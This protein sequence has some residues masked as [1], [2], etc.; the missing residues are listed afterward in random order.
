MGDT[1]TEVTGAAIRRI[2][3]ADYVLV[4]IRKM[5][6]GGAPPTIQM[7]GESLQIPAESILNSLLA[8]GA[9]AHVVRT[10]YSS[11][12]PKPTFP[13][14][15]AAR[16]ELKSLSHQFTATNSGRLIVATDK[17]YLAW[18]VDADKPIVLPMSKGFRSVMAAATEKREREARMRAVTPNF[19][20]LDKQ[21][22]AIRR[23]TMELHVTIAMY[24]NL[25]QTNR[26]E[27]G[28][29]E[30]LNGMFEFL[31]KRPKAQPSSSDRADL[32]VLQSRLDQL[33]VQARTDLLIDP[34]DSQMSGKFKQRDAQSREVLR[35]V[36][37]AS[38]VSNVKVLVNNADVAP[39]A[40]FED[41]CE[42]VTFAYRTLLLT[43]R[44]DDAEK[45]IRDALDMLSSKVFDTTGLTSTSNPS[46]N[47]A[48]TQAG[49]P[50]SGDSALILII[51][52]KVQ[53][54]PTLVGN[55]PGPSTVGAAVV[56]MA[57]LLL[58]PSVM[59]NPGAAGALSAKLYRGLAIA[60]GIDGPAGMAERVRLIEATQSGDLSAIRKMSWSS[61]FM[62]SQGWC[63]GIGAANAI[64]F[65]FAITTDDTSTLR[66]WSKVAATGSG[67][68][69]GLA[70][71]SFGRFGSLLSRGIITGTASNALGVV[72]GVAAVV[73]GTITA[74]EEFGAGDTTGGWVATAGAVGGALSVA[75]FLVAAGAA[76]SATG[77]G[78]PVGM[79]L[80]VVG[81]VLAVGSGVVSAVR[82]YFTAG[83]QSLWIGVLDYLNRPG[84]PIPL[85][86]AERPKLR[87][88]FDDVYNNRK[89]ASFWDV[90]L[91]NA[92]D[93]QDLG[94]SVQ[95]IAVIVNESDGTVQTQLKTEARP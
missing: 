43:P 60:A 89:S 31:L 40:L 28:I 33:R 57:G 46:F 24:D 11:H 79:G 36:R 62:T 61:R 14:L 47:T 39:A 41:V 51:K 15:R 1:P 93:L 38:F 50:P 19:S 66:K 13:G 78:V 73:S 94:F 3:G 25:L 12:R 67:A 17:P 83:S 21:Q 18:G 29:L 70:L 75:G 52:L 81:A 63:A 59:R 90:A 69:L 95:Q 71:T 88:A 6:G 26:Q 4:N 76:T 55:L 32:V 80:M 86:A 84:G 45:D 65:Y 85:T 53:T 72:G 56:E 48:V 42:T 49:S 74:K 10:L 7:L 35:L 82:G 23:A 58:M 44:A 54:G 16:A 64:A 27:V 20:D 9:N 34:P 5:F 30:A 87:A 91:G 77:V 68:A 92:N 8:N 37:E 2:R 22:K